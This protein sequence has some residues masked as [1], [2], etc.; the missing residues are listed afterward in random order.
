MVRAHARDPLLPDTGG[1]TAK[2]GRSAC[3]HSSPLGKRVARAESRPGSE[4]VTTRSDPIRKKMTQQTRRTR[5]LR[6]HSHKRAHTPSVS[7]IHSFTHSLIH[8]FTHSLTHSCTH[9]LTHSFIHSYTSFGQ[10]PPSEVL[11]ILDFTGTRHFFPEQH[12]SVVFAPAKR[13]IRHV[14]LSDGTKFH[15]CTTLLSRATRSV[16]FSAGFCPW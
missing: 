14:A 9:S 3:A 10:E 12:E 1:W 7:L 13:A 15:W 11:F 5:P 2:C 16:T 4:S 8:S 6:T